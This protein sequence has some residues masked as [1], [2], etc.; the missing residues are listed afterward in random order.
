MPI[1]RQ[2]RGKRFFITG[3][4]GF[5][6][7]ALVERILRAVPEAEITVLIR[8]GRRADASARLAREVIKNDC[9]DRSA[10]RTRRRLR[11]RGRPT[12]AGRGGGRQ[13]GRA[14]PRRRGSCRARRSGRHRPL[15]RHRVLRRAVDT[16][17]RDQ[18]PRPLSRRRHHG[19]LQL[20]RPPRRGVHGLRGQHAPG[21]GEGRAAE[22]EPL[23]ARRPV[24]GRGRLRPPPAR[25][26]AGRVA[27]RATASRNSPR[28]PAP[29]WAPRATTSSR[30]G[31][32][33]CAR[34][35]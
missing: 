1:E 10:G 9:F 32:R 35:G 21:R 30:R 18:P 17:R 5:L 12:G 13:P 4:T 6:G 16:G 15:R 14:G 23:H 11:R 26:P 33:S 25:R 2:L 31:P 8:P 27:P 22:R 29:T 34:N 20:G 28:R 3:A 24:A 19:R 7:T